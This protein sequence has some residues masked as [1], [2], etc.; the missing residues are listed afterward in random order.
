MRL[1]GVLVRSTVVAALGGLLFGFDTV[2]ISGTTQSLTELFHLTP[3]SLGVT[4]SSALAG[5]IIGSMLAGIPGDAYGRRDSLRILAVL[6]L[7]SA[8]GCGLAWNWTTL[9]TFRVIG[10]LAIGGSSVL[11]PMYIAEIAPAKYRGRLVGL[12]Q[13]NVVFGIL[14][15]YL[16]NYLIGMLKLGDAEW[17]W[18]LGIAALPAAIFL[19][20]L[21]GIPRSPRW[22]VK[23][24]RID[25]ARNVLRITGEENYEQELQDIVASI[26]AEHHAGESLFNGRY[27]LPIFLAVSIAMFNQLSGINGILYYL[28]QIFAQAGFSKVSSDLQAVAI[29]ATNLI[30]TMIAMTLIDKVGRKKLLLTGAVGT[31]LCLAGVSFVFLSHSHQSWLVWL[32]VAYIAFFAFS[33]GAVIWVYIGE[34]FPN[35]V[36]A[37]GQS[38]GSFAHWLMAGI[39]SLGFPAV[40][41]KSGGYPFVF[42]SAMMALQFFVVLLW[43]P[44]TK[45]ITLEEMQKKLG[46]A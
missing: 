5:T 40:A 24:K 32:L 35:R 39:I 4:V 27:N 38:L 34:V 30:F 15:A 31:T 6:Y 41:A 2:V 43:Y 3:L 7:V 29:G 11:G 19:M 37:A 28:N 16:S 42:F 13:F 1:N 8:I 23:K 9:V 18:K 17:R 26:D 22:L 46:I 12:F 14:L 44:E 33:Q 45:G 21:F 36:R 10:G 20:M 25:E